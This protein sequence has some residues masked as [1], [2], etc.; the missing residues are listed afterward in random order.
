MNNSIVIKKE[1]TKENFDSF[2]TFNNPIKNHFYVFSSTFISNSNAII[3]IACANYC[4]VYI[5]SNFAF[6]LCEKSYV[7]DLY[8]KRIDVTSFIKEGENNIAILYCSTGDITHDG[9]AFKIYENDKILLKSNKSIKSAIFN[10]YEKNVSF[11]ID[12]SCE[13]EIYDKQKEK[14]IDSYA[15]DS[16]NT[17]VIKRNNTKFD[18]LH[19]SKIELPNE[20]PIYPQFYPA[21][22]YTESKNTCL[23][24][25][26]VDSKFGIYYS[27]LVSTVNVKTHI[28]FSNNVKC[29]YYNDK[30]IFSGGIIEI[31][32]CERKIVFVSSS[33]DLCIKNKAINLNNIDFNFI[34]LPTIERKKPFFPWNDPI[35]KT[36]YSLNEL[37]KIINIEKNSVICSKSKSNNEFIISTSSFYNG[38]SSFSLNNYGNNI[39][40]HRV[41]PVNE[42]NIIL[43]GN[44][45]KAVLFD[46]SKIIIGTISFDCIVSKNG[47]INIYLFERID[48]NGICFMKNRNNSTFIVSNGKHN[49]ISHVRRGFRYALLT[50]DIDDL[51]ISNFHAL[52]LSYPIN[53]K[54]TFESSDIRLNQIYNMCVDTASSCTLDTYVDCP[55]YEQNPWTG[56]AYVTSLINLYNFGC[57]DIDKHYH[58]LISQSVSDSLTKYY[59]S[60]NPRYINKEFLPCA[61]FPTYPDGNIPIWSFMWMLNVADCFYHTNDIEF[62]NNIIK[63]IEITLSRCEKLLSN[64]DL[65]SING[66]WNLIEWANNDLGMYG[67][68]TSNNILLYA[69]FNTYSKLELYLGKTKKAGHY[70]IIAKRIKNAINKYCLD[71]EKNVY[72]DTVRDE[73]GYELYVK[74]FSSINRQPVSY[75]EYLSYKKVSVQTS[76]LALYYGIASKKVAKTLQKFLIDNIKSGLYV[77]G[78]PSNFEL[79]KT[80]SK[81]IPNG[82]VHIGSPFFLFYAYNQLSKMNRYDL[83]L[84]SVY[85]EYGNMLDKNI[86]TTTETF[87]S[88]GFKKSRSDCHAWSASFAIVAKRDILGISPLSP[89]FKSFAINPHLLDLKFV[90]GSVSTPFGDIKVNI[91]KKDGKNII[92]YSCPNECVLEKT[93]NSNVFIKK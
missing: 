65:L 44:G 73:Y 25:S 31:N 55:G 49:C 3:S 19:L 69:C 20:K 48:E 2:I 82:Y 13:T 90:K 57:F 78:T 14:D 91:T 46:F 42:K 92:E 11:F 27:T 15:L 64:R 47:E 54:Y 1:N 58:N 52:D 43:N 60:N 84:I 32:N 10:P 30:Q 21:L 24:S 87:N 45:K 16:K 71:K 5:N 34:T 8:Y 51:T 72:V 59:R 33:F 89:G 41:S 79:C 83:I 74:Y 63:P 37:N 7:F 29:C 12:P 6:R 22:N 81:L 28:F 80:D 61:C 35:D 62:L 70:K 36:N 9:I 4:E 23:I 17:I 56:D 85:R 40:K 76:T 68:V 38:K 75:T 93:D 39:V 53:N 66:A 77:P 67:E 86:T 50:T 88:P 26:P 18:D